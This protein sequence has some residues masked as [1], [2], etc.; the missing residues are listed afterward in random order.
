MSY[1]SA[2]TDYSSDKAIKQPEAQPTFMLSCCHFLPVGLTFVA[3]VLRSSNLTLLFHA[4]EVQGTNID[5]NTDSPKVFRHFSQSL[6]AIVEKY[7]ETSHNFFLHF[8]F[9][10][11]EG[12]HPV[13]YFVAK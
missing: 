10:F 6:Q 5:P 12:K 2:R 8:S 1:Y 9:N 3:N 11:C 13:V 7:F 4:R